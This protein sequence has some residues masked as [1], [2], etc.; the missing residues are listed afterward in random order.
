LASVLGRINVVD[1][2]GAKVELEELRTPAAAAAEAATSV[3]E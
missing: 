1:K 3:A 2:S